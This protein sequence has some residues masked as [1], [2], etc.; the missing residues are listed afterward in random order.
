MATPNVGNQILPELRGEDVRGGAMNAFITTVVAALLGAAA[1][2]LL[3]TAA[4][5][6]LAEE[7]IKILRR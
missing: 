7:I 6:I 5:V 4:A 1:V 3:L 2:A